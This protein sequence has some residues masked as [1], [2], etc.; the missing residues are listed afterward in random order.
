M[1]GGCHLR[2][3]PAPRRLSPRPLGAQL[4]L[5]AQVSPCSAAGTTFCLLYKQASQLSCSPSVVLNG[6]VATA[7]AVHTGK[8]PTPA[9]LVHSMHAMPA[10]MSSVY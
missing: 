6:A 7:H 1:T 2:P 5:L 9:I 3:L 10:I 8:G 4:S